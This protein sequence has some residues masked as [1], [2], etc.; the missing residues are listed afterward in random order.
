MASKK[1]LIVEKSSLKI[2]HKYDAEKPSPDQW[3]GLYGDMMMVQHIACPHVLDSECVKVVLDQMDNMM[4]VADLDLAEKKKD[5]AWQALRDRRNMLLSESD[6]T[7]VADSPL[8]QQDRDA[9]K[10][11]RQE[12]RDMPETMLDPENVVWPIKPIVEL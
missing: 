8:N 4:V 3:G 2:L 1:I 7:Q 11:Y 12:L 10:K 5:M 9:W 6:W